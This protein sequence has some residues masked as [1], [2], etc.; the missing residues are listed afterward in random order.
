MK[1]LKEEFD[2]VSAQILARDKILK[3]VMIRSNRELK[4]LSDDRLLQEPAKYLANICVELDTK[5]DVGITLALN[6]MLDAYFEMEFERRVRKWLT[7]IYD[8]LKAS[9]ATEKNSVELFKGLAFYVPHNEK[10]IFVHDWDGSSGYLV[11]VEKHPGNVYVRRIWNKLRR[12]YGFLNKLTLAH[13]RKKDFS[14]HYSDC[15]DKG[16]VFTTKMFGG[17]DH[18]IWDIGTP[19]SWFMAINSVWTELVNVEESSGLSNPKSV[20][21]HYRNKI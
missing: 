17:V 16:H 13:Y 10:M 6:W 8:A 9:G 4:R 21:N 20:E 15:R 2:L 5:Y 18:V 12:Q 11:V 14:Q 19:M 3:G 7:E 1:T